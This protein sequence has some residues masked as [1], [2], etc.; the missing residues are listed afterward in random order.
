MWKK[1]GKTVIFP[2]GHSR[3]RE[4]PHGWIRPDWGPDGDNSFIEPLLRKPFHTVIPVGSFALRGIVRM[5][6]IMKHLRVLS[7]S[8]I[9]I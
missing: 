7:Q 1:Y 3:I 6:K 4:I 9:L 8:Y 5:N 2:G